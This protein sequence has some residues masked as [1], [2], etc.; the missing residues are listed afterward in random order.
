MNDRELQDAREHV[1]KSLRPMRRAMVGRQQSDAVVRVALQSCE[2][3]SASGVVMGRDQFAEAVEDDVR[4]EYRKRDG[5][6]LMTMI[7]GWAIS[8]IV[9]ALIAYWLEKRKEKP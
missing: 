9:Q 1:W 5:F 2:R 7:L 4:S 3:L 6:V 8:A